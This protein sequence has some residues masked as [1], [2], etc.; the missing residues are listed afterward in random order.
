VIK[1]D[2][3]TIRELCKAAFSYVELDWE[4]FVKVDPRFVRPT[5]TSVTVANVAKAKKILN[6]EAKVS[7]QQLIN[8]MIDAH[9]ETLITY[10]QSCIPCT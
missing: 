7:F 3:A 9:L 6:W 1:Q 10:Q 8:H 2:P 4:K 5:E